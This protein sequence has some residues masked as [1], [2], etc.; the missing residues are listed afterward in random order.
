MLLLTKKFWMDVAEV[1]D[2]LRVFPRWLIIAYWLFTGWECEYI[3]VWYAHLPTIERTLSVTGFYSM[4]M[5]GLFGL[6]AYVFK[7]YTDGGVDWTVYRKSINEHRL[8][9]DQPV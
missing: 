4:V 7:V 8:N 5:G 2:A 3:T 9:A 1:L 6:A